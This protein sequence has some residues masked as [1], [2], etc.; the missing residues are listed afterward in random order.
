MKEQQIEQAVQAYVQEKHL[1]EKFM[2]GVVD[3]FRLEP[4]LNRRSSRG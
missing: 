2:N 4:K 3:S 1:F